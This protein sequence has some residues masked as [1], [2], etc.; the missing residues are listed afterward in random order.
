VRGTTTLG[1]A[2]V[3]LSIPV[4]GFAGWAMLITGLVFLYLGLSEPWDTR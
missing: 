2:L 4:A 3:L 1:A